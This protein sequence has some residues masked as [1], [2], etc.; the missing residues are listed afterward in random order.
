MIKGYGSNLDE[1]KQHFTSVGTMQDGQQF[2]SGPAIAPVPLLKNTS[3]ENLKPLQQ[4]TVQVGDQPA[5]M[6]PADGGMFGD[7]KYT[8]PLWYILGKGVDLYNNKCSG[9]YLD[10]LPAK[11]GRFGDRIAS[12]KLGQNEYLKKFGSLISKAKDETVGRLKSNSTIIR[13]LMENSTRPEWEMAMHS[14]LSPEQELASE[15][16]LTFERYLKA[17]GNSSL[18]HLA[19]SS[20]EKDFLRN[21]FPG[22]ISELDKINALQLHR[23]N[24]AKYKDAI[25][26]NAV[27]S[28]RATNANIIKETLLKELGYDVATYEKYTSNPAKYTKELREF[29]KKAGKDMKVYHGNYRI[30]GPLF[31]RKVDMSQ[32]A[33]KMTSIAKGAG[34][35]PPKSALGRGMSMAMQG[36]MRGLTFGGGK[37]GLLIFVVPA[38]IDMVKNAK[39]APDDQKAG[40]IAHGAVESVSWVATFPLSMHLMHRIGGLKYLGMTKNQVA[41][42]RDALAKFKEAN[43]A[44][45]FTTEKMYTEAWQKVKDLRKPRTKL[46]IFEKALKGIG[47]A[48]TNDLEMRPAWKNPGLKGFNSIKNSLR[49]K[50]LGNTL[51][52]L[53][54]IARVPVFFLTMGWV[55][56]PL[57]T[58]PLEWIFGKPY[59]RHE[60]AA[61]NAEAEQARI[62]AEQAGVAEISQGNAPQIQPSDIKVPP[63]QTPVNSEQ[64]SNQGQALDDALAVFNQKMQG[65]AVAHVKSQ[66]QVAYENRYIPSQ[67]C[68]IPRDSGEFNDRTYIP[69]QDNQVVKLPEE[70]QNLSIIEQRAKHAEDLA[71]DILSRRP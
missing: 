21:I 25:S 30:I 56:S 40:T 10:S 63:L 1:Y 50:G 52:H 5:Q 26:I 34:N 55:L 11:I 33:N 29:A 2:G 22:K 7:L 71:T 9:E 59:D 68:G 54:G 64:T 45:K 51:R 43:K 46:N 47:M 27:L 39:E 24:P 12:S 28:Q 15:V 6:P 20:A 35:L 38:L 44:G 58:K 66:A 36:L 8:L 67:N 19:P 65:Q 41:C 14:M 69:N 37:L 53:T 31:R 70:I 60:E 48:F 13:N 57:I 3:V 17:G 62:N 4:D 23:A 32:I 61:K 49:L 18:R 16:K 42:Y